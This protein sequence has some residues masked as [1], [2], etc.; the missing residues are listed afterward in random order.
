MS[1]P[2]YETK[3][4]TRGQW[5][6]LRLPKEA[7]QILP[8]RG[9]NVVS[10]TLNGQPFQAAAEP[11]GLGGHWLGWQEKIPQLVGIA[12]GDSVNLGIEPVTKWPEPEIPADILD[13]LAAVP[14]AGKLWQDL[15]PNAHWEWLRWIRSTNNVETRKK[16][17]KWPVLNSNQ[18]CAGHA[19]LTA[20]CALSLKFLKTA[21]Y[22]TRKWV[23]MTEEGSNSYA[24]LH[25]SVPNS[26]PGAHLTTALLPRL[27][28]T[29]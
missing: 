15:T 19:A 29:R 10:G 18:V 27:L 2:I 11:D 25:Q 26:E 20:I 4:E 5:T 6:I 13:G 1:K 17:S 21:F 22:W 7:S 9:M 3:V 24:S 14:P 8:S 16:E 23:G 28:E 12:E